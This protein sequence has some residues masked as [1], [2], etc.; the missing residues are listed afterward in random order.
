MQE[1]QREVQKYNELSHNRKV[2]RLNY[3]AVL[4]LLTL[5]I[6]FAAT[7]FALFVSKQVTV[8]IQALAEGTH[9]V[10]KGNLDFQVTAAASGELK[11]L[12]RSFN[13]MTRQLQEGS[14]AIEQA[15]RELQ[16]ANR[17]LEERSNTMEAILE[18][19][20]TGV[21][22]F[23]PE[24]QITRLNSTA[25]RMFR[26]AGDGN[27]LHKLGDLFSPEDVREVR[28]LLRRASRQG[29]ATQQIELDLSGRHAVVALTIS[30]IRARHGAVGSVLVL[31]DLTELLR[32]P[33]IRRVAGS[34]SATSA[35]N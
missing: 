17:E 4:G 35:R 23:D 14:R 19:I 15:T 31:E 32:R 9:Q 5:L 33:E 20:P 27:S 10:S 11:T 25:E 29:I 26:G 7:W 6:L 8:P 2:L 24:G 30:S 16:R 18:S 21:I 12:I 22:S 34:G 13:E 3:L 28:R 1:I